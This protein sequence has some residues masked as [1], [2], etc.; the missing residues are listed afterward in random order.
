MVVVEE[1]KPAPVAPPPVVAPTPAGEEDF[2][3]SDAD[4]LLSW[5]A[6]H[7]PAVNAFLVSKKWIQSGETFRD[8]PADKLATIE[9]KAD[10]FAD[11]AGI[12]DRFKP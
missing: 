8:L 10:A 2:D 11:A 5:L 7:E 12:P 9:A 1:T 3:E 4:A 6:D